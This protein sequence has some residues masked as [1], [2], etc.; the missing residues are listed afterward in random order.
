MDLSTCVY[1]SASPEEAWIITEDAVAV[2]HPDPLANCHMVVAPRRHV[3][4]F[5]DLDVQEQQLVWGMVG[6][7]QKRFA[8]A[9]KVDG[10]HV[11]FADGT[12]ASPIHAHIHVVPRAS[13]DSLRL[14][15]G[16]EWVET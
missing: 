12:D 1:C 8:S 11:G 14:P 15:S 6:E 5:Y 3:L 4:A 9:L 2:P 16:I 7:I 10:F 13:G